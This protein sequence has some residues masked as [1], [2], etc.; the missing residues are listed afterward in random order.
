MIRGAEI[1]I[2]MGATMVATRKMSDGRPLDEDD[3]AVAA[4]AV[5]DPSKSAHAPAAGGQGGAGN[6]SSASQ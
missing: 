3:A 5:T 4:V 1:G 6:A 2:V